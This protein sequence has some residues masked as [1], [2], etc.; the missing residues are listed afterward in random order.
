MTDQAILLSN[1]YGGSPY[2]HTFPGGIGRDLSQLFQSTGS[3]SLIADIVSLVTYDTVEASGSSTLFSQVEQ[4]FSQIHPYQLWIPR[5]QEV[6]NYLLHHTEV[7]E[8]LL[9]ASKKARQQF[10][11]P[12]QLL[13]QVTHDPEFSDVSLDLIVRQK[14]Y[15][16]VMDR[17]D[18]VRN[19]LDAIRSSWYLSFFITTDFA[20]I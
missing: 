13:L 18:T 2:Q 7:L 14:D 5:P 16:D 19:A 8:I 4:T 11:L 15:S 9:V 10:P 1:L 6:R 12:A 17:I 3:G 20:L